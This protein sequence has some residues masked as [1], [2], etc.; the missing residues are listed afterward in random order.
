MS[1][2]KAERPKIDKAK[3]KNRMDKLKRRQARKREAP[4]GHEAPDFWEMLDDPDVGDP[5]ADFEIGE[6]VEETATAEVEVMGE[7][8]KRIIAEKQERRQKHQNLTDAH[9]Y[10]SVVFQ[11]TEQKL[12]FMEAA[13][14]D[15]LDG[16]FE[17]MM[18][19]GLELADMMGID[20]ETIYIP[21]KDPPK[22]P[23]ALRS[24][25]IIIGGENK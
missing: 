5:F 20:L 16:N 19:N 1:K 9:Y 21:K 7:A 11:S 10:V 15:E 18:I 23:V 17:G 14:W 13:G 22:A 4:P 24:K 2:I 25:K 6:T 3:I 12:A 8:L